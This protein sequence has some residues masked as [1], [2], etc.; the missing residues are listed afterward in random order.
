MATGGAV[1]PASRR[2]ERRAARQDR[3]ELKRESKDMRRMARGRLPRGPR[4]ART[5]RRQRKGVI[6]R[7]LQEDVLYL[8][9]VNLPTEEEVQRSVAEL[10]RV[11]A[12]KQ[13]SH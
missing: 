3:R 8:L 5:P 9:V 13:E 1:N 2:G 4:P 12:Q 7:I 10:Q 11:M 6:K